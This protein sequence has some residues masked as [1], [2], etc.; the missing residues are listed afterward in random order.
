MNQK[1]RINLHAQLLLLF[2]C[3]VVSDSA[4]PWTAAC[5]SFLSFTISWS[6]LK[7]MSTESV[8]PSS[9]LILCCPFLLLLQSFQDSESF[10][11]NWIFSSGGQSIG[12]SASVLPENV[13]ILF[14]LGLTDLIYLQSKGLSRVF[15]STT[16]R[17]HQFFGALLSLRSNSDI[18]T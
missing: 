13:Q 18:H 10:P 7:L 14:P 8:T 6:T 11:P 1:Y 4:T 12:A 3:F 16:V 9:H 15:F 17:K 5:Q 2:S